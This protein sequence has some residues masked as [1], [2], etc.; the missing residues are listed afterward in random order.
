MDDVA[1]GEERESSAL[2]RKTWASNMD[3]ESVK[4]ERK[5]C[6]LFSM[7]DQKISLLIDY[8]KRRSQ[9]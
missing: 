4:I 9:H 8:K 7:Q 3:F 6:T 2:W 1:F 5:F